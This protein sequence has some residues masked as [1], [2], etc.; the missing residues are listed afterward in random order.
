LIVVNVSGLNYSLRNTEVGPYMRESHVPDASKHTVLYSGRSHHDKLQLQRLDINNLKE[1]SK[2]LSVDGCTM[3]EM[4]WTIKCFGDLCYLCASQRDSAAAE[5]GPEQSRVGDTIEPGGE[6]AGDVSDA[7]TIPD[8]TFASPE[9][10]TTSA[11]VETLAMNDHDLQK[12]N[13]EVLLN[14]VNVEHKHNERELQ[15]NEEAK[16]RKEKIENTIKEQN[17]ASGMKV[18]EPPS[19]PGYIDNAPSKKRK[20]R[21]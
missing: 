13:L 14:V 10:E 9:S 17:R 15:A 3:C 6:R 19:L 7:D 21:M 12:A 8:S 16:A 2:K 20:R 1:E 18:C 4:G 5:G 11:S